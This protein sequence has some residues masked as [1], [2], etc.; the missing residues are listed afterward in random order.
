MKINITINYFFIIKNMKH[1]TENAVKLA[2]IKIQE[3]IELLEKVK[4]DNDEVDE[5]RDELG[6]KIADLEFILNS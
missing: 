4:G 5:V 3:A 6:Y 2:M 1:K